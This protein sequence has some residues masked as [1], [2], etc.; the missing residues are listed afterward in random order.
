MIYQAIVWFSSDED[1]AKVA[2][3]FEDALDLRS[4]DGELIGYAM[5]YVAVENDAEISWVQEAD[6]N[7]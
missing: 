2:I 5:S 4:V 6:K 7:L 1:E 3:D